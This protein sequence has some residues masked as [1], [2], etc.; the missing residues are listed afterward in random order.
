MRREESVE[1]KDK[2]NT[3]KLKSDLQVKSNLLYLDMLLII[4]DQQSQI[5]FKQVERR[6]QTENKPIVNYLSSSIFSNNKEIYNENYHYI[7][8]QDN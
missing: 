5:I 8:E 7:I 4:L 2:Q 6:S 3:R 1:L